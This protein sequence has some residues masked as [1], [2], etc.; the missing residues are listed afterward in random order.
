MG[1]MINS[2]TKE[3]VLTQELFW[4]ISVIN[5]IVIAVFTVIKNI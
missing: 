3:V 5:F 2:L 4:M 1:E